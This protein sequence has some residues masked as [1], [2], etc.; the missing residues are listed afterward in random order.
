[1]DIVA[2]PIPSRLPGFSRRWVLR[3]LALGCA[4]I[5]TSA[6]SAPTHAA[7]PAPPAL[8]LANVLP[9][10]I[11][12][13]DYW[14][15]EKYDG[16]RGY[17]SGTQLL[18][19]GGAPIAAPV[20]FTAGW[21]AEPMDGELWAGRGRFEQASSTVRRQTP[22]DEQW[23]RMRYLVF[24]LPAHG[25]TF[26]QRIDALQAVVSSLGQAW[27]QAVAQRKFASR[28]ELRALLKTTVAA[29]GEGLMLHRGASLYQAGRS[30]DLLKLKEHLD[31][32]ARVLA[33]LPGRGKYVG[34]MGALL[35]EAVAAD[36]SGTPLRFRL[37]TGFSDAERRD[38]PA[39]G[40]LVTYRYRDLNPSGIPRFASFL[41]VR[42]DLTPVPTV[43]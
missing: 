6:S 29:G 32:E 26:T 18:T 27:V 25:G 28:A 1:M 36:G 30:D 15:S 9:S 24:D 10:N 31:A 38:P 41:R 16:V 17:W 43:R 11:D 23:R 8:L 35:V 22:D 7:S 34:M 4:G 19:R 42:T 13:A 14:V 39:V 3:R 37:G 5:L 20:W 40:T 12:L 21:P 2:L 33:I